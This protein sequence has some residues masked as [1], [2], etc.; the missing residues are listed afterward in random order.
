M[1]EE[2]RKLNEQAE[3][4]AQNPWAEVGQQFAR[5]G[6]GIAAAFTTAWK[7]EATQGF[8]HQMREGLEK[9]AGAVAGAVDN[10]A[11]SPEGQKFR[12]EA[13]KAVASAATAGKQTVENVRPQLLSALEQLNLKVRE[14][15]DRLHETAPQT[16][17]APTPEPEVKEKPADELFDANQVW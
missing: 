9:M 7:D 14:L 10:A 15:L 12:Q 3:D 2:E 1:A 16:P 13:E 17:P 4:K 11:H 8:M 6:E 5:L